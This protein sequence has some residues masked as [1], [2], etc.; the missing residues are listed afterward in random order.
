MHKGK[1]VFNE[2]GSITMGE[3]KGLT[4][5][6]FFIATI[7][8]LSSLAFSHPCESTTG[9]RESVCAFAKKNLVHTA[10]GYEHGM[11]D[12]QL[13]LEIATQEKINV[14]D[15]VLFAAGLLHDMGGFAPYEK[16]GVDH[17]LRSTEVVGPV[18]EGAGFPM[19]KLEYVKKAILTHSYYETKKPET[20]EAILLHDADTLDFMGSIGVARLLSLV[21]KEKGF[22]TPT[23]SFKILRQFQKTLSAKLYG[24]EY[25]KEMGKNRV[26]EMGSFLDAIDKQT[27]GVNF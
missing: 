10:W 23:A 1:W 4:M 26:A 27:Y 12:Y 17:A 18:L 20:R 22:E 6:S 19:A 5:K 14:D 13:A 25:T 11:R 16:A 2:T 15:D 9:W 7:L 21:G 24:G 3:E 8:G